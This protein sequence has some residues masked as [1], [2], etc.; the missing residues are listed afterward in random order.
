MKRKD[1]NKPGAGDAFRCAA[2][3]P[4]PQRWPSKTKVKSKMNDERNNDQSSVKVDFGAKAEARIEVKTEIPSESSG[5]LIDT[6]VDIIRPFSEKR[7]LKADLIRLQREEVAITIMQRAREKLRL[8]G[9]TQHPIPNKILLPILEKSSLEEPKS[10]LIDKWS[11]LLASTAM[12]PNVKAIAFADILSAIGSEQA[13][14][15]EKIA[16]PRWRVLPQN[17]LSLYG[18]VR[19]VDWLEKWY[20]AGFRKAIKENGSLSL[21]LLQKKVDPY[22]LC[23]T[24]EILA[25]NDSSV[26]PAYE[27]DRYYYDNPLNFEI[28]QRQ[29][30][31]DKHKLQFEEITV[32]VFA[33]TELGIEFIYSVSDSKP[34][35]KKGA[36]GAS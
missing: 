5:R 6:L 34:S 15:I 23:H 2:S 32:V 19:G 1:A 11:N 17:Q 18:A 16:T 36:K 3:A 35:K 24:I 33:L 29:G 4:D 20:A 12:N 9:T 31:I 7:G 21:S 27:S 26:I 25:P 14:L 30:L 28:L 10:E 13:I 8:S 22:C